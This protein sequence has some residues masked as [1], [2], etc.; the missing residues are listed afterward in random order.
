MKKYKLIEEVEEGDILAEPI[1]NSFGLLLLPG[2][3][4]LN[5][6]HVRMFKMWNIKQVT[7]SMDVDNYSSW[8]NDELLEYSYKIF[9][10]K[11]LWKP[12]SDYE[13]DL[14]NMGVVY[15]ARKIFNDMQRKK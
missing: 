5:D 1:I 6:R 4:P 10:A 8:L 15:E 9:S 2:G 12:E 3:T 11:C 7:V 14:F 13:L